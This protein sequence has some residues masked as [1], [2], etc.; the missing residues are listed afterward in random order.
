[1]LFRNLLLGLI[2]TLWNVK[3]SPRQISDVRR[4]RFNRNI[5]ECKAKK[6]ND[7]KSSAIGLIE[8][9]WNVKVRVEREE[10]KKDE[11]LIETLWN[12]KMRLAIQTNRIA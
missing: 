2:E 6:A 10:D 9:L 12:V 7:A 11:G 5:V 4:S 3:S 1:M 8:T